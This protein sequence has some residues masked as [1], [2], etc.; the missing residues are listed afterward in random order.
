M[1]SIRR[2]SSDRAGRRHELI[3]LLRRAQ[4]TDEHGDLVGD[5]KHATRA[6]LAGAD[7]RGADLRWA[8]L[9]GAD[10]R[11]ADLSSSMLQGANL[12]WATL[13]SANLVGA[14][15][16]GARLVEATLARA[17]L[18]NADFSSVTGL[19]WATLRDASGLRSAILPPGFDPRR[20]QVAGPLFH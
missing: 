11:G 17:D 14:D 16:T 6:R 2:R 10:L 20:P 4:T 8:D 12:S 5:R 9:A 13:D 19:T 15:L 18:T 7:L 3:E 1:I